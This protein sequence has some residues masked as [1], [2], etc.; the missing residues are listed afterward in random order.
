MIQYVDDFRVTRVRA[1]NIIDRAIKKLW[2]LDSGEI[3]LGFFL[4]LSLE[5]TPAIHAV[6]DYKKRSYKKQH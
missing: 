2:G 3:V 4:A 6:S 1:P 5:C